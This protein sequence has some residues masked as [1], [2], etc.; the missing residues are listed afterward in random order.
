[1]P[2]CT[3]CSS[4]MSLVLDKGVQ[5]QEKTN[6]NGQDATRRTVLSIRQNSQECNFCNFITSA[7]ERFGQKRDLEITDDQAALISGLWK[8]YN[9]GGE[10]GCSPILESIR[11]QIDKPTGN[12][13][14][15][16][17]YSYSLG[18]Y[19]ICIEAGELLI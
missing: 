18:N 14:H 19:P 2:A 15:P 10:R 13:S 7:I 16:W 8:T 3:N 1:M 11:F 5:T 6:T 12:E 17:Q 4:W 9:F